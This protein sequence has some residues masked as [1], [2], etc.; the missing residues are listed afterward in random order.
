MYG[1]ARSVLRRHS[2][3]LARS[4]INE[5]QPSG[6][7]SPSLLTRESTPDHL[8]AKGRRTSSSSGWAGHIDL[9]LFGLHPNGAMRWW[10]RANTS[11]HKRELNSLISP[12]PFLFFVFFFLGR[13]VASFRRPQ[14]KQLPVFLFSKSQYRRGKNPTADKR[15]KSGNKDKSANKDQGSDPGPAGKDRG[16]GRA[17][18]RTGKKPSLQ[19]H[20]T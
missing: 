6:P 5:S 19:G 12:F 1:C 4:F 16:E 11:R 20:Q 8:Q 17:N 10:V 2:H 14:Q 7:H 13:K 3:S 9:D 18:V 15:E